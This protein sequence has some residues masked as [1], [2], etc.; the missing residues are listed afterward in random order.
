MLLMRMSDLYQLIK[1]KK[2]FTWFENNPIL[3]RT[4]LGSSQACLRVLFTSLLLVFPELPVKS[5]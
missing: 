5:I 1:K 4:P 3:G 2:E